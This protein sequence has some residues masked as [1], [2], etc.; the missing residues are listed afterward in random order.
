MGEQMPWSAEAKRLR[1]QALQ[2][3]RDE[4][5]HAK[6]QMELRWQAAEKECA[7]LRAE[8]AD[9]KAYAADLNAELRQ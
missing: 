4:A 1:L 6:G 3:E 8:V 9:L 7:A 2:A 5:R